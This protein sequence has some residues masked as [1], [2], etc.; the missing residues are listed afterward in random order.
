MSAATGTGTV[1]DSITFRVVVSSTF[2]DFVAE[3]NALQR[4]VWPRLQELCMRHGAR[5][6]AID[7]RWGISEQASREQQIMQIC[8][9]EI[10]RCQ[11]VTPRP[12]FIVLLGDRYGWRPVPEIIPQPELA[13]IRPHLSDEERALVERWY[14]LDENAVPPEYCLLSR[15]GVEYEEWIKIEAELHRLLLRGARAAG[16]PDEAMVTFER[17]ATEQEIIEGALEADPSNAF[18]YIRE[19]EGLPGDESAEDFIDLEDGGR[20]AEAARLLDDLKGRLAAHLSEGHHHEISTRWDGQGLSEEH[21]QH[22]CD[23]IYEDLERVILDEIGKLEAVDPLDHGIAQH[24]QFAENRARHFV[25]RLQIIARIADYVQGSGGHPLVI[26]GRSGSGKS[27]LM[28]RVLSELPDES[29]V[30]SR[31]VGATPSSTQL[32]SLLHS[33][34]EQMHREF[35][36]EAPEEQWRE[37]QR[38]VAPSEGE[39]PPRNPYE[40][41][42]DPKELPGAFE[43]FLGFVPDDRELVILLDALD[44]LS[45]DSNAHSLHWLPMELPENVRI[46]ASVLERED[47]AGQCYRAAQRRVPED[48]LVELPELS[49]NEGEAILDAWLEEAGRTLQ[50]EQRRHILGS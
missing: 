49:V 37:E 48:A 20:D 26:S 34:C 33:L 45:S 27:A 10:R 19:I 36:F 30:I 21:V 5:F 31:F 47:E 41:P 8:L 16:L 15:A 24:A 23:L 6:Q 1:R 50:P 11:Q 2:R 9:E 13:A 43:R 29:T 44:Q 22:L 14:A 39:E 17:S 28:A 35:G 46:V 38:S 25:G 18:S 4:E 12:N 42:D 32:H 7:L 3:R 40:V